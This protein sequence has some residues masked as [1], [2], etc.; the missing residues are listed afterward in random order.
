M[1]KSRLVISMTR[2]DLIDISEIGIFYAYLAL[3]N[4]ITFFNGLAN[5]EL[6]MDLDSEMYIIKSRNHNFLE[7]RP[8]EFTNQL[9]PGGILSIMNC[10]KEKPSTL[11]PKDHNRSEWDDIKVIV[12]GS[13]ALNRKD[14]R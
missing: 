5:I 7:V 11:S 1:L 12:A 2:D 8:L 4:S 14:W 10:L 13:L 9:T 3:G 6:S